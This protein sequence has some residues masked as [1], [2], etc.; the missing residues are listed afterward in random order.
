MLNRHHTTCFIGL[1]TCLFISN[2]TLQKDYEVIQYNFVR[3]FGYDAAHYYVILD[4]LDK[5]GN[6]QSRYEIYIKDSTF[7]KIEANELKKK[8]EIAIVLHPDFY[9]TQSYPIPI[10]LK[11]S[12]SFVPISQ[13]TLS[14]SGN[15]Q[16]DDIE[17]CYLK[18]LQNIQVNQVM[19]K[20]GLCYE[21]NLSEK[22]KAYLYKT[23]IYYDI[24]R[25]LIIKVNSREN[26]TYTDELL[27]QTSIYP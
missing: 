12:C 4:T 27:S 26:R 18:S 14:E 5:Q 9:L 24:D 22:F 13:E 1:L 16:D 11:D 23:I 20:N 7:N 19:I 10:S 2:C 8:R 3:K 25:K 6:I 21:V 15:M 17:I